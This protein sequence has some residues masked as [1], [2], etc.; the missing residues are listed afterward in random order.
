MRGNSDRFYYKNDLASVVSAREEGGE[1]LLYV[2][3][4][5][6]VRQWE[7][8]LRLAEGDQVRL[9]DGTGFEYKFELSCLRQG[10]GGKMNPKNCQSKGRKSVMP[11]CNGV[12]LKLIDQKFV[13]ENKHKLFL[14][15]GVLHDRARMEW[16]MEKCTELGVDGFVPIKTDYSQFLNQKSIIKNQKLKKQDRLEKIVIEAC[17]QSGRVRIPKIENI[18]DMKAIFE[19]PMKVI[20][21]NQVSSNK[22][23]VSSMKEKNLILLV[24][25]EGGWSER[26]LQLFE[27]KKYDFWSVNENVLRSETAAVM[28]VGMV[29]RSKK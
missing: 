19:M 13:K 18:V 21:M 10:F 20:V 5:Q 15:F 3:D 25:P 28:G 17:E 16:M 29:A 7:K 1:G 27:E 22:F 12:W 4:K 26:E 23:Q 14:G 11:Y 8:V 6:L 2:D 9:F 24:G